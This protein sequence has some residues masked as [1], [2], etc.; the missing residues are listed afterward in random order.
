MKL[1]DKKKVIYNPEGLTSEQREFIERHEGDPQTVCSDF[2]ER[3]VGW[4][5]T[6]R[7]VRQVRKRQQQREA[8]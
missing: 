6:R 4:E 1:K 7:L 3:F 8:A 5:I 2:A